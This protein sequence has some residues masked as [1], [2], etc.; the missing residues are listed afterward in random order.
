MLILVIA[1][2]FDQT[3]TR[4]VPDARKVA[5]IVR[6]NGDFVRAVQDRLPRGAMVFELP[7]QAF[8]EGGSI[9]HL[10]DYEQGQ[11]Y[12]Y[13]DTLR[14]SYGA[15]KGRPEDFARP[16]IQY[17]VPTV[18][19][20][21]AIAGFSAVYV[22]RSGY[23]DKGVSVDNELSALAGPP[24]LTSSDRILELYDLR[25]LAGQLRAQFP[26]REV[27]S[28]AY[29]TLHQITVDYGS[30]FYPQESNPTAVW[31]WTSSRARVQLYNPDTHPRTLRLEGS[32]VTPGSTTSMAT[33][34][35]PGVNATFTTSPSGT[36]LS[37]DLRVPPGRS[38][39]TF[40]TNA[41]RQRVDAGDLRLQLVNPVFS[42]PAL[43]PLQG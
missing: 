35:G 12:L 41:P 11:G 14:W 3:T 6:V 15:M 22:D 13:S 28:L 27:Q 8:P 2:S 26:P 19:R 30:G 38:V 33:I 4:N 43:A 39:L 36:P 5:A 18:V 31:R 37:V 23:S 10:Q 1:G 25:P 24:V 17:P 7:Y 42:D 32:L 40:S 20:G 21:A 9:N 34:V 29:A 16:L